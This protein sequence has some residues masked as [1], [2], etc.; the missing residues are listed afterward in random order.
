[1]FFSGKKIVSYVIIFFKVRQ[2][3]KRVTNKNSTI[4]VKI[5]VI[6]SLVQPI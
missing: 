3:Y 2:L 5:E 4:Q 6:V 1:M